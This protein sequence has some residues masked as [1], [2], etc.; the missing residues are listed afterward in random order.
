MKREIQIALLA[1]VTVAASIW[2]FKFISGKSL[3]SGDKTYYAVFNDVKDVNTATPILINGLQVGSV[4]SIRPM[5]EDIRKIKVGFQV[6]KEIRLPE[7]TVVE[8]RSSGALGGREIELVFDKMC[9]GSNCAPN[10]SVLEG[11]SVGLLGS[12]INSEDLKPHI[13]N[14]AGSIDSTLD[15][16]GDPKSDAAIDRAIYNLAATMENFAGASEKLENVI[17][18]SSRNMEIT[19]ANMAAITTSLANSNEQLTGILDNLEKVTSDLSEASLS[20]TVAKTN[21]TMDQA[22]ESL[23]ALEN[24]MNEATGTL[25]ELKTVIQKMDNTEGSLGMLLNDKDLYNNIESTTRN[26]DLLLQ[27]LRL[28]PRRYFR[29]FG[30]KSPEY[31]YPEDDPAEMNLP[32]EK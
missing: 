26:L 15:K 8:L 22:Q 27:D 31:E 6:N 7:Y 25:K 5:S 30:K 21:G 9:D 29:L 17:S 28:N 10:N 16:L 1:I 14:I 12:L 32:D 13:K 4:I 2:G 18:S 19:L 11:R 20:E 24:T 23:A 3:F